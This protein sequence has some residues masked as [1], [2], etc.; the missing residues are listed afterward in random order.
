MTGSRQLKLTI[1]IVLVLLGVAIVFRA[2]Y[3]LQA[4]Q[5]NS[6]GSVAIELPTENRQ[7]A[8]PGKSYLY[9]SNDDLAVLLPSID[10][11]L[12]T[13]G[14][15]SDR[16]GEMFE[17][18]EEKPGEDVILQQCIEFKYFQNEEQV[19]ELTFVPRS[20]SCFTSDLNQ[21][22]E[23]KQLYKEFSYVYVVALTN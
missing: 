5:T 2:L 3:R 21:H 11:Y 8:L 6:L 10:M 1:G 12:K 15:H 4:D 14:L 9:A 19:V 7:L 22:E 23:I 16:E 18:P 17:Y 20:A 13:Q